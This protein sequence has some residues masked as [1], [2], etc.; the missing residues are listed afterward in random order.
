MDSFVFRTTVDMSSVDFSGYVGGQITSFTE[1]EV[2]IVDKNGDTAVIT[3][4]DF[5]LFG[6][7]GT[8]NSLVIKG[9]DHAVLVKATGL[10]LDLSALYNDRHD[11]TA[12]LNDLFSG[13]NSIRSLGGND[14]LMGFGGNDLLNGGLGNDIL[15]GGD[16]T[17]IASYAGL[18]AG[19]TVD[20]SVVGAQDT[21]G[22]G[23]DTLVS[24]ESLTGSGHDDTLTGD[25]GANT[26]LGGAGSDRISGGAGD[27]TLQGGLGTDVIIG[28]AGRDTMRG[29]AGNDLFVFQAITDSDAK[30]ADRI[31]DFTTGDKISL[32]AIDADAVTA[33]NQDFHLGGGGGHAGDLVQTYDAVHDRTVINLYVDNNASIDSTIWLDGNHVLTTADIIL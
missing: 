32:H 17:D 19:V 10:S 18:A 14:T 12:L 26:I 33:G 25:D 5:N 13:D 24:I 27:D 8:I 16:G 21:G 3:G 29:D 31:V 30:L 28:G 6:P 20:L 2:D 9:P 1:T 11:A 7:T 23:T 4:T 15:N 22:G